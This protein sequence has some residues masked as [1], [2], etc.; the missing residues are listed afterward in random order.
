MSSGKSLSSVMYAS[1]V[2]SILYR[3]ICIIT[4]W[5]VNSVEQKF[6]SFIACSWTPGIFK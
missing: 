6:S 2:S 3:L 1:A 4:S 5:L